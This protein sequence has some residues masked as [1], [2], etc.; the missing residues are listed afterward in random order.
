MSPE[1]GP[2][3]DAAADRAARG[4]C[5]SQFALL[6]GGLLMIVPGG[7]AVSALV[8]GFWSGVSSEGFLFFL[9]NAI[10]ALFGF[11]WLRHASRDL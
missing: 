5:A 4:G 7:C 10:L 3:H 8:G 2:L 6:F 11:L 1:G 9:V